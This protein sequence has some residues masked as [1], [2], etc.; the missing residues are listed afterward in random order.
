MTKC[1][2]PNRH[3]NN[4]LKIMTKFNIPKQTLKRHITDHDKA[5]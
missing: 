5:Q 2:R 1:S 4:A 3:E